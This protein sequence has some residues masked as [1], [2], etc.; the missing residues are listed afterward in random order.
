MTET[1]FVV[2]GLVA[3]N[4]FPFLSYQLV[5]ENLWAV[6]DAVLTKRDKILIDKITSS[7][8]LKILPRDSR[9]SDPRVHLQAICGQWLPLADAALDMVITNPSI[10]SLLTMIVLFSAIVRALSSRFWFSLTGFVIG[11]GVS[12]PAIALGNERG[13]DQSVVSRLFQT[14]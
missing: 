8:N 4:I 13:E 5:L 2:I 7:L 10:Q 14:L 11:L 6:Y 12:F 3:I 9:N 1:G